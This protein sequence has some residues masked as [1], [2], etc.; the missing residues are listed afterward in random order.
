VLGQWCCLQSTAPKDGWG[1]N[2][3][4]LPYVSL[5]NNLVRMGAINSPPGELPSTCR[6]ALLVW[7]FFLPHR[8][9]D[10]YCTRH[11]TLFYRVPLLPLTDVMT[12]WSPLFFICAIE[13]KDILH[14]SKNVP[15]TLP[16]VV[17]CLFHFHYCNRIFKLDNLLWKEVYLAHS[18]ESREVGVSTSGKGS[19]FLHNI[20]REGKRTS[21]CT[22]KRGRWQRIWL[23]GINP[24]LWKLIQFCK[25]DIHLS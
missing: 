25:E 2:R 21:S 20:V 7:S 18:L 6:V 4:P 1:R 9:R 12:L 5:L 22:W 13:R 3:H 17:T 16:M 11:Q 19:M 24:F 14:T 8:F 15:L 23:A 10:H